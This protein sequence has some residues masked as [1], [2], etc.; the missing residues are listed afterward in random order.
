MKNSRESEAIKI[1]G[2]N[3]HNL[4]DIDLDIPK[5]KLVVI[6]GLS[7]SGKSS[8]AFDT[9]YAEAERR[10]VESLS[11]YARQFLGIKDKPD[12]ES[13]EGLSPAIS[14]DQKSISKN[15]RSTVGTITEIYDYLRILFARIG[16]PHCPECGKPIGKQTVDQIVE[17]IFRLPKSKE[18]M[19]LA[20]L[21]RG[22]KG[23][24][25]SIL[26]EIKRGGFLRTRINDE[27]MLLD[28]A[29]VKSLDKQKKH[30]IEVVVDR[31]SLTNDIERARVRDSVE[32]A[33]KIGKG[34]VLMASGKE[35]YLFSEKFACANCNVNMPDVE[36]RT[37]SFNS[38]YGAC[39]VC[40]GL[41]STL[42]VDPESVLPNRRL[43]IAEGAIRPW[44]SAS[45]RLGRQSWYWWILEDLAQRHKFSLNIPVEKLPQKIINVI[46]Y[47]ETGEKTSEHTPFE[48]VIPNLK[49]R[50]KETDSDFTRAEIEKYMIIK[51]CPECSGKRLRKEALAVMV[52]GRNIASVTDKTVEETQKYFQKLPA[53]LTTTEFKIA[54]PLIKEIIKRLQF[55]KDVGL[56]YLTL[57]RE[58]TTLAGGEAQRIQLATQIGSR[59]TGIIYIL[60]EPSIGLHPRDHA[61]LIATLKELRDL[62]NTVIVVEH[63]AETMRQADW[64][65]DLGPGAGKHGGEIIFE[66]TPQKLLRAKTLTGEYLSGKRKVSV[67]NPSVKHSMSDKSITVIGA[68]EH[69]LKNIDV[70]IPLGKF[71]CVSGVSGSGKSTLVNDVL[72]KALLAKFYRAHLFPGKHKEIIGTEHI[73][74]VV[75][76]DQSPIG[77]TPRSN[78]ATYTGA[79]GFIRTVFARTPDARARGY[80]PGRFSFNVRGGRCEQCEGQGVK[81]IEMYF[82]PDV[83]VEC[84]ECRGLRYNREALEI[85]YNGKNIS[86]VLNM[87]VEEALKFFAPIPAINSKLSTLA[88]VGLGYMKVG[89][90]APTL[91]GGEAQRVKLATELSRRDT[92]KTLY[93]LDE[94]TTG[95][96]FDDIRKLLKVLH[97]L[98]EKGNT[99]LVIEHNLDVLRNAD[100]IIDLG[101]E[102]GDKG[103]EVIAEGRPQDIAQ[104][105]KSY[106]GRWLRNANKSPHLP[107][108]VLDPAGRISTTPI[109]PRSKGSLTS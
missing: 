96:H 87:S 69:N 43:T 37:F 59:L 38:P 5:N 42:E 90:P 108:G 2:A 51:I 36:P 94:P 58:S 14:I 93:I 83:F 46:L 33:L 32:T 89:Q 22:K 107:S 39:P 40:T 60:D 56:E 62:G 103:G 106:T 85:E 92:G 78:P 50:W 63:D 10:F 28:E 26:E 44:A 6:T 17:N 95:L 41:G 74:K 34:T 71:V 75:V 31:F 105:K 109:H 99:V 54:T 47:G 48:G 102:G 11:A 67:P 27:V 88:E 20:P 86:E 91:S 82:L 45:H 53:S 19:I 49:R 65:I 73:N 68:S 98:V 61:R 30:N 4:K 97:T 57:S 29:L 1:R 52:G 12:I 80:G 55:L 8:L 84:E 101:P 104:I 77:R 16:K 18:V 79:F 25:K 64:I 100:W 24:H 13:I 23:E 15:P 21:V 3:V 7:G 81:K 66:G 72:A 9:I 70:K 35:D 76:V